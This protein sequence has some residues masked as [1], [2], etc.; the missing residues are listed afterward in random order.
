MAH[1]ALK[2][3][4]EQIE[5]STEHLERKEQKLKTAVA[6]FKEWVAEAS[7]FEL[8]A[9]TTLQTEI[10]HL[11]DDILCRKEELYRLEWIYKEMQRE[12]EK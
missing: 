3:I 6:K 4:E 7:D 1:E 10:R 12:F 2:V 5:V 9:Q 8:A 11:Y